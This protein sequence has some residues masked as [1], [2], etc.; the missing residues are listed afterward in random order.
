MKRERLKTRKKRE[1]PSI[2]ST[3]AVSY[4]FAFANHKDYQ[5]HTLDNLLMVGTATKITAL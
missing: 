5:T 3:R 1:Y 2:P 4:V